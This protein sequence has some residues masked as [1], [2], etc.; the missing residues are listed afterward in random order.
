ML[1]VLAE[2]QNKYTEKKLSRRKSSV[3]MAS[4]WKAVSSKMMQ[5]EKVVDTLVSSHPEYSAL[6][7]GAMRFLFTV[8]VVC[9]RAPEASF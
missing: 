9:P 1:N 3:I 5:Y 8:S 6:V 4:W 7:W 2:A